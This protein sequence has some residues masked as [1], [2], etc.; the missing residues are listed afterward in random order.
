MNKRIKFLT[1][2]VLKILLALRFSE[3]IAR[4]IVQ[5]M[6]FC[7]VGVSNTLISYVIYMVLL[8]FGVN[9]IAASIAGFFVSVTNAFYWNN[10]YIFREKGE[11]KHSVVKAYVKTA[12]SY[13]VTGLVLSNLLLILWVEVLS[14]PQWAGPII[15][16][17]IT[18][19]VNFFLNK[20]WAFRGER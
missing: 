10:K 8:G 14:V 13:S 12:L 17:I 19:P 16:L 1:D 11:K 2:L 20:F 7:L 9:Y 18:V 5:F 3:K 15:N 6:G 4:K